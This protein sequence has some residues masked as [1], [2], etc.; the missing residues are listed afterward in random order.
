MPLTLDLRKGN[1]GQCLVYTM[2]KYLTLHR[3]KVTS[4]CLRS[5]KVA[6]ERY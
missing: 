4:T 2:I 5:Q 1:E 6:K 3:V